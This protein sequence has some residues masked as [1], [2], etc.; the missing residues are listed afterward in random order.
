M[1]LMMFLGNDLV[2]A[3]PVNVNDLRVP[4]YLGKFKR[5]LKLKYDELIRSS[6]EKPEFLVINQGI[7][8]SPKSDY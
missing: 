2:E 5:N 1:Q 8:Q 7:Q 6:P 4:G 3:V